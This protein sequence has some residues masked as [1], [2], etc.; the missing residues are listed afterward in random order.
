LHNLLIKREDEIPKEWIDS[1]DFSD[2]DN[3]K[4]APPNYLQE[5]IPAGAPEDEH[6][7]RL[8]VY[9]NEHHAI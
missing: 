6:H 4:C 1:D 8:M 9:Q 5:E 2:I 3:D 7:Q